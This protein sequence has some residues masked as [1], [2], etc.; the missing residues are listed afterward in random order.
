[1][2]AA[3]I[4]KTCL[5]ALATLFSVILFGQNAVPTDPKLFHLDSVD[6]PKNFKGNIRDLE[7]LVGNWRTE[8][9]GNSFREDTYLPLEG[10]QITGVNR[11]IANNQVAY[12]NHIVIWQDGDTVKMNH[13]NFG[14]QLNLRGER[15][16]RLLNRDGDYF[17]FTGLTLH[18]VNH[19][20]QEAYF[21]F[22][23]QKQLQITKRVLV[24]NQELGVLELNTEKEL[25]PEG[26]A[27]DFI[28][29]KVYLNSTDQNKIVFS[30]FDGKAQ[31]DIKTEYF[32]KL[33]GTGLI[34]DSEYLY[35]L[36]NN[37]YDTTRNAKHVSILQIIDPRSNTLVR[38]FEKTSSDRTMFNDMAMASN[39]IAYITNTS[40]D[41]VY[42]INTTKRNSRFEETIKSAEIMSPNGISISEKKDKLFIATENGIRIFDLKNRI[43]LPFMDTLTTGIDGLKF[44][45]GTLYALQNGQLVA[46]QLDEKQEA[47][48]SS[49]VL[50]KNHYTFDAPTSLCI[51]EDT[52][53]ILA[54]S[55]F[56]KRYRIENGLTDKTKLT[57][58]YILTFKV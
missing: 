27:V 16:F 4:K 9:N 28:H 58:T 2:K 21:D 20:L 29:E 22:G 11:A 45:K 34:F 17:Y 49:Q 35:A 18:R 53:Y 44:N 6:A 24:P 56:G 13:K 39:G 32:G 7:W 37:N 55:Q 31:S 51:F 46:F 38:S 30:D 42:S 10:R 1:M 43:L 8:R 52:I 12:M 33:R 15:D 57:N 19:N 23:D 26:L 36:G 25:Y 3:M 14:A 54:N 5:L 47:I 40:E 48:I 41:A 50:I